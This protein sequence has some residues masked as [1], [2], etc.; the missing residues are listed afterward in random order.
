MN[1]WVKGVEYVHG[2]VAGGQEPFSGAYSTSPT[3]THW[4]LWR[5]YYTYTGIKKIYNDMRAINGECKVYAS[6]DS[7]ETLIETVSGVNTKFT[8]PLD[9]S[10]LTLTY[11]SQYYVRVTGNGDSRVDWAAN[12]VTNNLSWAAPTTFTDGNTSSAADLSNL[13]SNLNFLQKIAEVPMGTFRGTTAETGGGG[14]TLVAYNGSFFYRGLNTLEA[15]IHT[16]PSVTDLY[17]YISDMD[18]GNVRT[19]W[20]QASASGDYTVSADIS[21]LSPALSIGTRYRVYVTGMTS[22]PSDFQTV[23]VQ[24]MVFTGNK[25][26]TNNPSLWTPG[27]YALGSSGTNRLAYIASSLS[28]VYALCET[29]TIAGQIYGLQQLSATNATYPAWVGETV[30]FVDFRRTRRFRYLRYLPTATGASG[31]LTY[32]SATQ[33]LSD[34]NGDGTWTSI[35]LETIPL[36]P[37]GF[38]YKVTGVTACFESI[39]G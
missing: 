14:S 39:S 15:S 34:N 17:I 25:A 11:G 21:A 35:D 22:T 7:G 33:T 1:L 37:F 12:P 30:E 2:L 28:D 24:R 10:A 27:D 31:T 36:L 18:G 26:L 3:G 32:G 16:T 29:V 38:T 6:H 13:T 4:E 5:G 9:L 19:V 20:H 23:K 8:S